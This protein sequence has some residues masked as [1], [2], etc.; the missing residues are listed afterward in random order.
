MKTYST[1]GGF[2]ATTN[3][4]TEWV[5]DLQ[6]IVDY[7]KRR[8]VHSPILINGA[9]VEQDERFK[10]ICVHITNKLSWSKHTKAVV[11]RA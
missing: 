2:Q 10:I 3:V 4:L 5:I 8:T 9:V 1:S 6:M 7:R 11:K